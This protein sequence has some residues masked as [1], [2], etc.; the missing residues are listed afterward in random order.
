M[1]KFVLFIQYLGLGVVRHRTDYGG[2][3]KLL[4]ARRQRRQRKKYKK[5]FEITI[6]PQYFYGVDKIT[7]VRFLQHITHIV[8]HIVTSLASNI[9]HE[10]FTAVKIWCG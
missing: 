1:L 2:C 10:Q 4:D 3:L 9:T 7:K 8:T 6:T 5:R